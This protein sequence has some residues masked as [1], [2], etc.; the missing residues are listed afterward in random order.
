MVDCLPTLLSGA[1]CGLRDFKLHLI[2]EM[3]DSPLSL[4]ACEVSILCM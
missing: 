3:R 2:F 1:S 4:C